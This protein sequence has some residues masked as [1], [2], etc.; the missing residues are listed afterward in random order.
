MILFAYANSYNEKHVCLIS[1][2]MCVCMY[3]Q[4]D[5][6][7]QNEVWQENNWMVFYFIWQTQLLGS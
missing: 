4:P 6:Y 7:S 5:V 3:F 1:I 2:Y